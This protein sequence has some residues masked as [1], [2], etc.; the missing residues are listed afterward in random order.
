M[1]LFNFSGLRRRKNLNSFKKQVRLIHGRQV[2]SV[3]IKNHSLD[4]TTEELLV[5]LELGQQVAS[6]FSLAHCRSSLYLLN[7]LITNTAQTSQ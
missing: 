5:A 6:I 7:I 2:L 1:L 4:A 3:P